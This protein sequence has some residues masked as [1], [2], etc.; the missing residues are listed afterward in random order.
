MRID[1][2]LEQFLVQLEANGRSP[3][4]IGQ[5]RRH[6]GALLRWVRGTRL[7][8]DVGEI[9]HQHLARFLTSRDALE[10]PDGKTK[11]ATSLN[12]LRSSLRTFFAYAHGAGHTP[13]NPARKSIRRAR[14]P[15]SLSALARP[16]VP[17]PENSV[18]EAVTGPSG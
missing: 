10:R 11:R 1:D 7:N 3:H 5:Y 13:E 16:S 6:I 2:V 8:E 17:G 4:T 18:S 12:T 15:W 9:G 14:V